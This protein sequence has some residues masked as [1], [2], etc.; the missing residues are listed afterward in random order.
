MK[1][2]PKSK[3]VWAKEFLKDPVKT[4]RLLKLIKEA[5]R[6]SI[7]DDKADPTKWEIKDAKVSTT[8]TKKK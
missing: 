8:G 5:W 3:T 1:I 4:R 6:I 7:T 2:R